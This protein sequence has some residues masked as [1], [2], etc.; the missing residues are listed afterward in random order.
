ML[1]VGAIALALFAASVAASASAAEN[2]LSTAELEEGWI[3]L[4]DGETLYGWEPQ[5]D[6]DWQV[7]DGAIRVESGQP[8]LLC[9]TTQFGDF[10]LKADFRSEAGTNSGI[11]L[12][13]APRPTNPTSDCYE[14]N[15]A[16]PEKSPF[17]TGSL[18]GRAKSDVTSTS[19]EWRTL[20]VT[21]QGGHFVVKLDGQQ[22]LDYTDPN[23]LG[24]G[25]IGL[26]LNKGPIAFRNLKLK[27]LGMQPIF[28]GKNLEGWK[29]E[30]KRESV[31]T[32][33]DEGALHVKNGPG[34]LETA[35]S[36]GDFVLQLE[37]F[38]NGHDLNSGIFFRSIPGDFQNG[39]ESQIH[40]GTKPGTDQPNNGGTGGIFRRQEARRVVSKDF[41]WTYKTII[42]E[43]PHMAVWVNGIQVS[44]WTDTRPPHANPRQGKRLEAGTIN[45][46]G[47]DPTT[48]LSFRDFRVSEMP[49]RSK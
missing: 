14:L 19:S 43:G 38:V 22:V 24:R 30:L 9:T 29:D 5:S 37:V 46:Q 36:Y 26:Q 7:Q 16:A 27:P 3:L 45:L 6:A 40:N 32:V 12:R 34:Q 49:P 33:T 18:V 15:I 28:N 10:V 17:P 44:D 21:C 47:H 1:R 11:F 42:A 20:E 2:A 8:G 48:D 39:Y 13:T 23:P 25:Y 31:F 35:G 4:F 41:E